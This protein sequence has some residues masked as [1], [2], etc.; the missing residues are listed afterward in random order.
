MASDSNLGFQIH[1]KLVD[2]GL[3]TPMDPN[4]VACMRGSWE[5]CDDG[6]KKYQQE[7]VQAKFQGIMHD[8]G[9]DVRRDDSLQDTPSRVSKM[10]C[11]E[12]FYGLDYNN[13][14]K[15]TTVE[16]KMGYEEMVATKVTVKSMC[17]HHFVPFIGIA[18]LAYL[19]QEKVLG[20]SKFNR[21][22][23]FFSRRPQIQERLT[24]QISAAL[25][26]ILETDNLAVVIQ[27]KHYCVHLRGVQDPVSDTTTSKMSGKFR[28]V[29][30]LRAEFLALTR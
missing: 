21:V 24:E 6:W 1:Q 14:P 25:G 30:E 10:F 13:F 5:G 3:E 19:P 29:P 18:H 17:E 9:L 2:A 22:V 15:C 23:D 16:N 4:Y 12:I 8:L 7:T 27:A 11:E 20:L 28:S 26:H